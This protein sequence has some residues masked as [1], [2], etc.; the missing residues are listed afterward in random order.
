MVPSCLRNEHMHSYRHAL[1]AISLIH[2]RCDLQDPDAHS[3]A[4]EVEPVPRNSRPAAA[5]SLPQP[6]PRQQLPAHP[7]APHKAGSTHSATSAALLKGE[8][9]PA[10]QQRQAFRQL[11]PGQ[12]SVLADRF[13]QCR[14]SW[15][16]VIM[17]CAAWTGASQC[18]SYLFFTVIQSSWFSLLLLFLLMKHQCW[19]MP[20]Q[21]CK[22]CNECKLLIS[23]TLNHALLTCLRSVCGTCVLCPS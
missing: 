16:K 4:A 5:R 14:G 6:A 11:Q 13:L 19:Y 12:G 20:R 3:V 7:E 23:A 9:L 8:Q 1:T 22:Y 17:T 15:L 10:A 2:S 18:C 21:S